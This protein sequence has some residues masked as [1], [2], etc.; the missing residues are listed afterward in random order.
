MDLPTKLMLGVALLLSVLGAQITAR[1]P[2]E[3]LYGIVTVWLSGLVLAAVKYAVLRL[4]RRRSPFL[5]DIGWI[6]TV[7]SF[8]G[9]GG[10]L[11]DPS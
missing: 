1:I 3:L 10:M 8:M 2:I 7:L 6:T 4:F 5:F 9:F 11:I